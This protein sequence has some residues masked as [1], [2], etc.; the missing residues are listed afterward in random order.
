MKPW[1][2]QRLLRH[3]AFWVV[4]SGLLL[5]LQLPNPLFIGTRLYLRTYAL[6]V[7]PLMLPATYLLLYGVLPRLLEQRRPGR[8]L[9]LLGG[10]LVGSALL[11][12]LL[13]L[14]Y[15][16]YLTPRWFG[17]KAFLKLGWAEMVADLNFGFFALLMVAGAASA[18]QVVNHWY[19]QRQLSQQLEQQKLHTELE[20]LKAQ[21]QPGFLFDT[22]RTL[23]GL[24]AARAPE[25]PAAVLHLA[26]LLRYLLY[27]SPHE[28]VPLADEVAMLRDYVALERLRLGAR[29]EVSL[30]FS[31]NLA[32]HRI[33]PLLLLPFLENA[34]RHGTGA[35]LD[36][37]WVS[38]DLVA[39]PAGLTLKIINSQPPAAPALREGLGLRAVRQ[40]LARLYAGRHALKIM[41]EPDAFVVALHLATAPLAAAH[42]APPAPAFAH[43]SHLMPQP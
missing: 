12:N 10:W 2:F 7:L 39:R 28:N 34:F 17:G 43:S 3:L 6:T 5:L 29:V 16:A 19:E 41:V 42:T 23:R 33:A 20:L 1:P 36:C 8:F 13:W 26:A 21:L 30:N 22:L 40:R 32:A 27:E 9:A 25:A 18:I 11:S 37:A 38:I 15:G 35:G 24:T 31:G 14:T 4:A